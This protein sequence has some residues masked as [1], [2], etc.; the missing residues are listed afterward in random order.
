M[1]VAE[2]LYACFTHT[3]IF[4][5]GK[6]HKSIFSLETSFGHSGEGVLPCD[7][8]STPKKYRFL[9]LLVSKI[10]HTL[11]FS[12]FLTL[13][14]ETASTVALGKYRLDFVGCMPREWH[15]FAG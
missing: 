10:Y 12:S 7:V 6:T 14:L 9:P 8:S 3:Y 15:V 4:Y 2:F 5:L 1:F 13:M 11:Q